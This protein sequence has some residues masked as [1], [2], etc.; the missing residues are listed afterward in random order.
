MVLLLLVMLPMRSA[1][2]AARRF[3]RA[4]V[5]RGLLIASGMQAVAL[6]LRWFDLVALNARYDAHAYA[7]AAW[8]VVVLHGTLI[9]IDTFET[10]VMGIM[11]RGGHA[12]KKHYTDV[13]DAAM[14]QYFLSAGWVPYYLLIYWG[15]RVL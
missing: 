15:P 3:D 10:G 5:A 6:V 2:R 4:G 11:F 7:S 1:D 13:C 14:Y 12:E 9:V 8:A